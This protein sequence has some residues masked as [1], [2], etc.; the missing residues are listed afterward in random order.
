[1]NFLKIYKLF[2]L[3]NNQYKI[4]LN[5]VKKVKKIINQ[6]NNK[7]KKSKLDNFFFD[8]ELQSI[9][10]CNI[11]CEIFMLLNHK[12]D[13]LNQFYYYIHGHEYIIFNDKEKS[14]ELRNNKYILFFDYALLIIIFIFS[15]V[16]FI[17]TLIYGV[18]ETFS[19]G[20]S[21]LRILLVSLILFFISFFIIGKII[22][23]DCAK[24]LVNKSNDVSK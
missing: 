9:L 10:K 2:S 12:K 19:I 1:M 7:T 21:G 14:F 18:Y 3:I 16:S 13:S 24:E 11:T 22:E 15:V 6:Y 23:I 5:D 8:L 17:I 20:Y 4:K